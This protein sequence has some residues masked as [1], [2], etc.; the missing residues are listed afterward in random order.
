MNSDS[1]IKDNEENRFLTHESEKKRGT[2]EFL[3]EEGLS[4][5]NSIFNESP[6][7]IMRDI[8]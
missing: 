4:E 6:T 8:E 3:E 2:D 7:P 5:G 1:L